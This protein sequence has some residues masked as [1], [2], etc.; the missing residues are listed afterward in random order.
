MMS[1]APSPSSATVVGPVIALD[2]V[3][4]VLGQFPAL[5]GA[6]LTVQRG[7]IVLLRGPNGAGK[8]T[9]LRLCAGLLPV[10]RGTATILGFDLSTQ[11]ELV[12]PHVGLL[13]HQNGLYLD[14]SVRE[15]VNFWGRTVGAS[16]DEIHAAMARMGVA[17]L[18]TYRVESC[19][20]AR[21]AGHR[22]PAS[23][24]D[25]LR[26]GSST[27]PTQASTQLAVT[28]STPRSPRLQV[29]ARRSWW[30][31]TSSSGPAT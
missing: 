8:T 2:D 17:G 21:S 9:L 4:A 24:L 15:N 18:S 5:A 19:L 16:T 12:R 22:W 3:V 1:P 28:S 23:L 6:S 30:R 13:G 25:G 20:Q 27:N 14:L 26:S 10:E 29:R 31:A 11:R 7:E